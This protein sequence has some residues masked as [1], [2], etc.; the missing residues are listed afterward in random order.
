MRPTARDIV[1]SIVQA[2]H[3]AHEPLDTDI[4]LVPTVYDVLIHPDAYR[5][6]EPILSRIKTQARQRLDGELERLNPP[7][8]GIFGRLFR[9]LLRLF[10]PDHRLRRLVP[11]AQRIE[12]SGEEWAIDVLVAAE[13]SARIDYLAV[14]T[15]FGGRISPVMR[16]DTGLYLRRRT[17][18][19][20]DGGF[21][22]ILITPPGGLGRVGE[23]D[24][25]T[26]AVRDGTASFGDGAGDPGASSA[27][28]STSITTPVISP[29]E[30]DDAHQ[31]DVHPSRERKGVRKR[32]DA[33]RESAPAGAVARL[34]YEDREGRH[35]FYFEK[36]RV[37]IGRH[38]EP[39]GIELDIPLRTQADVSREHVVIRRDGASFQ[40]KNLGRFG[41]RVNGKL[42]EPSGEW[43]GLPSRAEINLADAVII[44]FEA[45]EPEQG[46]DEPH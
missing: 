17:T 43:H 22:T 35:T 44:Q 2:M 41:T 42:L 36:R 6:L 15:D 11:G 40:I 23:Q 46:T 24:R 21:E 18:R 39:S 32:K 28:G 45:L 31:Q 12:R 25:G 1:E 29:R 34:E 7:A 5:E 14:E 8:G 27:A 4:V 33:D 38:D 3:D 26:G 10:Y 37:V 20:P 30:E 9:P 19:K 13:P 16:G